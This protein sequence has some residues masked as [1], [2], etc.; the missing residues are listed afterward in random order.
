M[1][2]SGAITSI[3][4]SH[5][6]ERI[7][8]ATSIGSLFVFETGSAEPIIEFPPVDGPIN[9]ISWDSSSF[10]VYAVTESGSIWQ[11]QILPAISLTK[12]FFDASTSFFSCAFS[13]KQPLLVAGAVCG[14]LMI[15]DSTHRRK[16][17]HRVRA[18]MQTVSGVSFRS[19]GDQFLTC[20]YD[21]MGRIWSV[22]TLKCLVSFSVSSSP[23]C[24]CCFRA[25]G[26]HVLVAN[27]EGGI[28]S[29]A[30]DKGAARKGWS[31][32]KMPG[33]LV[34][35]GVLAAPDLDPFV[36]TASSEGCVYFFRERGTTPACRLH[37]HQPGFAAIDIH[38]TLPVIATG[39]GPNDMMF[40]LWHRE[41]VA[42]SPDDEMP[43]IGAQ[44][45]IALEFGLPEGER[46]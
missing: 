6:G 44:E 31:V 40:K 34:F 29:V 28:K 26:K 33:F 23:L 8:L 4:F 38:P 25:S 18:H 19:D 30:C 13:P 3:K 10:Y 43:E 27:A 17:Q 39:G 5:L 46:A 9:S 12:L 21:N 15:I 1:L 11:Y 2:D 32:P 42:G 24:D 16:E 37:A 7:A 14:S 35:V 45:D 22:A 41:V 36:V 20:S